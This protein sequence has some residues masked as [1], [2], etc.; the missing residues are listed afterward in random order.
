MSA[1]IAENR[2]YEFISIKH[3]GEVA[4][5]IED[6][7]S[8]KVLAWAPAYENYL[9][10]ETSGGTEIHVRLDTLLEHKDYMN[11]TF[12]KALALL[13]NLCESKS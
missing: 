9:F 12:P 2:P 8:E 3:L 10:V 6:T 5:G 1:V 11:E 4:G 13:K 7:T